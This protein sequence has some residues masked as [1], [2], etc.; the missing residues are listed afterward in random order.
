VAISKGKEAIPAPSHSIERT[1][2]AVKKWRRVVHPERL[3]RGDIYSAHSQDPNGCNDLAALGFAFVSFM[4]EGEGFTDFPFP[5][6]WRAC[7]VEYTPH[8]IFSK[9]LPLP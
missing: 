4:W 3:T 2:P 6:V 8:P 7:G 1:S 9:E 5:N